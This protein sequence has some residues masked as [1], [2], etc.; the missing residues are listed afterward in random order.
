ML[1]RLEYCH[2]KH[3]GIEDKRKSCP[4]NVPCSARSDHDVKDIT[5]PKA[6]L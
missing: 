3:G 2:N 6:Y 1:E 4:F 5:E